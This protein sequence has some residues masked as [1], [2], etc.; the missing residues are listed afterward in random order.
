MAYLKFVEH[1]N[2]SLMTLPS[3][4]VS[5]LKPYNLDN[6]ETIQG[7][8]KSKFPP[9]IHIGLKWSLDIFTID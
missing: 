8:L 6:D 4:K 2:T 1:S 9:I 5:S 3:I 7:P